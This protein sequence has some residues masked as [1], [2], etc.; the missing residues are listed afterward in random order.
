MLGVVVSVV[1]IQAPR[2]LTAG[3]YVLLG[4]LAVLAAPQLVHAMPSRRS[5]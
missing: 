2:A 1:W 3:L 4:W 5:C